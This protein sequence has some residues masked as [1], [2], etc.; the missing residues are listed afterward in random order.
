MDGDEIRIGCRYRECN[1]EKCPI[2]AGSLYI[3]GPKAVVFGIRPAL[4]R[5][6]RLQRKNVWSRLVENRCQP[7]RRHDVLQL[8]QIFHDRHQSSASTKPKTISASL[9]AAN[10]C[11]EEGIRDPKEVEANRPSAEMLD[12]RWHYNA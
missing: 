4:R 2:H 6:F 11:G 7:E 5:N 9:S 12:K 8:Y 10:L 1:L 3:S